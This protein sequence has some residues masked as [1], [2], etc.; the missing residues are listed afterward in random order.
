MGVTRLTYCGPYVECK[1]Q[2]T[3]ASYPSR[4]CPNTACELHTVEP[5]A[6]DKFCRACGS[7]IAEVTEEVEEDAVDSWEL[8]EDFDGAMYQPF[9]GFMS[10]LSD[11]GI[12]IWVGNK[13]ETARP[14]AF[15]GGEESLTELQPKD[16]EA[17][18]KSFSRSY[19]KELSQLR[20]AY[21]STN[22]AVKWGIIHSVT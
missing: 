7:T 12:H 22:V 2:K 6:N 17:E 11:Q 13:D 4:V 10:K 16:V 18:L 1:V 15:Y 14:L 9:G 5:Q 21:G 3:K 8:E 19:A 20:A